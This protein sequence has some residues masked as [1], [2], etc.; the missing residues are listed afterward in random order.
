[1]AILPLCLFGFIDLLVLEYFFSRFIFNLNIS[2][3]KAYAIIIALIADI[4]NG[5]LFFQGKRYLKIK[6]MFSNE[7]DDT[8]SKRSFYCILYSL[9]TIFGSVI[10]I[11]IFGLPK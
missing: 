2:H 4:F 10:L 6:E 11:G 5:V 8:R 9:I 7:D 3:Y 1:M